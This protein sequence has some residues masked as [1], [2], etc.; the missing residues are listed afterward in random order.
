M[1]LKFKL[2][3]QFR[4]NPHDYDEASSFSPPNTGSFD[5][6]LILAKKLQGSFLI[7]FQVWKGK[8][9]TYNYIL[10]LKSFSLR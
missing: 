10:K 7:L 8:K 1:G 4:Y 9:G 6:K 3:V 5:K 2:L